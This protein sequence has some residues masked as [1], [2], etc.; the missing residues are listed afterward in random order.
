MDG[1]WVVE[2]TTAD[3]AADYALDEGRATGRVLLET[4]LP[5][6][7]ADSTVTD[8]RVRAWVRDMVAEAVTGMR[9]G[10]PVVRS[11]P[12]LVLTG[13]PGRGK[14]WQVFGALRALS[15]SGV[16]CRWQFTTASDMLKSLRPRHGIDSFEV[17][18]EFASV[19]LLVIDDLG[20]A[21]DSPWTEDQVGGIVDRRSKWMRP[22]LITTNVPGKLFTEQFGERIASRLDEM[23]TV[24]PFLGP[25]L[26]RGA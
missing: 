12:S 7:Y 22:T 13:N 8:E 20:A 6:R 18:E 11:G 2:V 15:G 17:F 4:Q 26:R 1:S 14:T 10:Y 23:A 19:P 16:F 24:V 21:K 5:R 25:D 3:G 9:N